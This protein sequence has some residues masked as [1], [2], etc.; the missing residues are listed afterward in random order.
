MIEG[1]Q[2]LIH[3]IIKLYTEIYCGKTFFIKCRWTSYPNIWPIWGSNPWPLDHE[4]NISFPWCSRPLSHQGPYP[5]VSQGHTG[6]CQGC[7]ERFVGDH[8]YCLL[9]TKDIHVNIYLTFL[10]RL[11]PPLS[12]SLWLTLMTT[13]LCSHNSPT[14]FPSKR[15]A[16][17]NL[18]ELS[19]LRTG[20]VELTDRLCILC[21]FQMGKLVS[22]SRSC[23]RE[24]ANAIKYPNNEEWRRIF[25][26]TLAGADIVNNGDSSGPF[27]NEWVGFLVH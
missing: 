4:Q 16:S 10:F 22:V 12:L 2:L 19:V 17:M 20:I 6:Q 3:R 25:V 1:K 8:F 15:I 5:F 9:R 18:L 24:Q 26:G 14:H 13:V 21:H 27:S 7:R 11:L 23:D